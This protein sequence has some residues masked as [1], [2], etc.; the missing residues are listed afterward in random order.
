MSKGTDDHSRANDTRLM[1]CDTR[2]EADTVINDLNTLI[3]ECSLT[4]W[5]LVRWGKVVL[6]KGSPGVRAQI[7]NGVYLHRKDN[8]RTIDP[9]ALKLFMARVLEIAARAKEVEE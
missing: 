4:P 5:L 2:G 7:T 9:R 3:E 8:D 6:R 1:T